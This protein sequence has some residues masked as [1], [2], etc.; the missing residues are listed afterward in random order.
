[1]PIEAA[2]QI[3]FGA[4]DL[5]EQDQPDELLTRM[6]EMESER[7]ELLDRIHRLEQLL[8]ECKSGTGRR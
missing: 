1:M 3:E 7:I 5:P 2:S 4:L 8:A 6:Q